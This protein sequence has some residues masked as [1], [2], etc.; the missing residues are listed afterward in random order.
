[1]KLSLALVLATSG[2]LS[3]THGFARPGSKL[4]RTT[5]QMVANPVDTE[6]KPAFTQVRRLAAPEKPS[7]AIPA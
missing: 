7:A 4:G 1:M 6:A 3:G 5:H 2:C